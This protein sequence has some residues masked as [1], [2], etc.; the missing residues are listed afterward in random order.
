M[1][2]IFYWCVDLLKHWA[3]DLN[4]T[5]EEI[6]VWLFVIIEPLLIILLIVLLI[7]QYLMIKKLR[8]RI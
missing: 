1:N 3:K 8:I 7:R 2:K 6:N 4:M 5:Y